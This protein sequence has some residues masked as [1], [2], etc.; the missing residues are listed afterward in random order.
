MPQTIKFIKTAKNIIDNKNPD[1]NVNH[2]PEPAK[3]NSLTKIHK[4]SNP[5]QPLINS[6]N[7]HTY[8]IGKSTI[9]KDKRKFLTQ[10]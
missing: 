10:N 3:I 5:I 4:T 6:K 1:K 2:N 8:K 9:Y 7:G